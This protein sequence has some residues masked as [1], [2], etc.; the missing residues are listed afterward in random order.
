MIRHLEVTENQVV[1]YREL[2]RLVS[3]FNAVCESNRRQSRLTETLG[4]MKHV[5]TLCKSVTH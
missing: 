2:N 5:L 3:R 4:S 1:D